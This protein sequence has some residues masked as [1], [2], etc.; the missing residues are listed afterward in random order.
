MVVWY[1]LVDVEKLTEATGRILANL[2]FLPLIF[3]ILL[4][5]LTLSLFAKQCYLA[6]CAVDVL[7]TATFCVWD[8]PLSAVRTF[9]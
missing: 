3:F 6:A 2:Q 9:L 4:V 7:V 5:L 8:V 1:Q